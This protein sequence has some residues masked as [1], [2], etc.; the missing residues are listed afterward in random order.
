MWQPKPKVARK[1]ASVLTTVVKGDSG[2]SL[3]N[4]SGGRS[5][6]GHRRSRFCARCDLSDELADQTLFV[7]GGSA[8]E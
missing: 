3:V 4:V 1:V 7:D 2:T 5:G 6:L 8:L